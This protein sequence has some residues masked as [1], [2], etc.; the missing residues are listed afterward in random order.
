[1]ALFF[2]GSFN[3]MTLSSPPLPDCKDENDD[4]AA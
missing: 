4:Y 1:M 3:G 2:E